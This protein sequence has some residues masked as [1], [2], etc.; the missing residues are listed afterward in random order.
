MTVQPLN[1]VSVTIDASANPI[2]QGT[3]VTFTA[4]P[5]NGGSSPTYQWKV[6]GET[7]VGANNVTYTYVPA[8][9]DQVSCVLTSDIACPSGNPAIS[10]TIAMV[11]TPQIPTNIDVTDITINTGE[12]EC[13]N[14]TQQITVAGG[15]TVFSVLDGG[16]VTFIAGERILFLPGTSVQS[17][18]CLIGRISPNG[19]FCTPNPTKIAVIPKNSSPLKSCP[20]NDPIKIYPNP[21]EGILRIVSD[22]YYTDKTI[23]VTCYNLMGEQIIKKES[24]QPSYELDLRDQP[25]GMYLLRVHY[26]DENFFFKILKK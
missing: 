4:S 24:F 5:V 19:P 12:T 26:K 14:A 18:G 8:N 1:P 22:Q 20:G 15:G 23:W 10:N 11:V 6:N 17:G 21:T 7:I 9:G 13:F 2:C 25:P 16:I 3:S